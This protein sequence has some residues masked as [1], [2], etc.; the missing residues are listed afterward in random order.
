MSHKGW[1]N[2]DTCNWSDT[3]CEL[4]KSCLSCPRDICI[5]EV[6][7]EGATGKGIRKQEEVRGYL[8]QGLGVMEISRRMGIVR[9][10]VSTYKKRIMAEQKS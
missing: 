8:A 5:E 6:R 4:Y 9:N 1:N 10:Q 3:G 7:P 2:V